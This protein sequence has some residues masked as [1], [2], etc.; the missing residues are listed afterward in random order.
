[1]GILLAVSASDKVYKSVD[2]GATWDAGIA[3][4]NACGSIIQLHTG[5]ILVNDGG[6]AGTRRI[7]RDSGATWSTIGNGQAGACRGIVQLQNND[8]ITAATA[9]GFIYKSTD[10]GVTYEKTGSTSFSNI[11]GLGLL[12]NGDILAANLTTTIYRSTNGGVT[13]DT[14]YV[15]PSSAAVRAFVQLRSGN[16]IAS[17]NNR[18]H[19]STDNGVSFSSG[20][21][22]AGSGAHVS[23][24]E[25][26]GGDILSLTYGGILYKSTDGGASWASVTTFGSAMVGLIEVIDT[27][28]IPETTGKVMV[29]GTSAGWSIVKPA[30]SD[31]YFSLNSNL[32][33][34]H[35]NPTQTPYLYLNTLTPT[36]SYKYYITKTT[37]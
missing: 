17:S 25:T 36:G 7:S 9:S 34:F 19:L 13:W 30:L 20:V 35:V 4:G 2:G 11:W 18:M 21:A 31:N 16:I 14:G 12:T 32:V 37:K 24:I 26:Y 23:I 28:P 3:V 33:S 10:L 22:I 8:I 5:T 15:V 27:I 1:M 6:S 29:Q